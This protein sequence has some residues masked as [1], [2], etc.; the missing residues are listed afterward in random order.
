M[1]VEHINKN[2]MR[3]YV[4]RLEM[5]NDAV[6]ISIEEAQQYN[7]EMLEQMQ[8]YLTILSGFIKDCTGEEIMEFL[9][10]YGDRHNLDF[11]LGFQL[12]LF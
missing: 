2:L 9:R 1:S 3:S 10:V 11:K 8:K 4:S 7:S 12:E 5:Q 6:L